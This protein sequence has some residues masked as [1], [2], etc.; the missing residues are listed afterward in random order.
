[1]SRI[2]INT[3]ATGTAEAREGAF[4]GM[5]LRKGTLGVGNGFNILAKHIT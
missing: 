3:L 5:A 1:M 4:T 2:E